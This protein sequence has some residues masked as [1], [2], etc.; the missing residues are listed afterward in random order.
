MA[1]S[2]KPSNGTHVRD[3]RRF[4][5]SSSSV[6]S[7]P[8]NRMPTTLHWDPGSTFTPERRL[9]MMGPGAT[10]EIV[11]E[12]VMGT[13]HE[14]FA[15]RYPHLRALF[16][17][18]TTRNGDRPYLVHGDRTITFAE[19]RRL[20]AATA[21]AL[22][23]EHDIGRGDRVAIA[24][25][26]RYEF[27]I[28]AWAV[29]V[30]G[31]V[32]VGLNGWWTGP[33]LEYG[34]GLTHPKL[35]IG[36]EERLARLTGL[37]PGL[38]RRGLE[39]ATVIW[40]EGDPPLPEVTIDEDD[41]FVILFTSGTTGRPKGAVLT[42]RNNIHWTQSIAL[43]SAAL[44]A[45]ATETCEIAALPLFHISGLNCQAISSVATGTKLVYMPPPGRWSPESQ[46]ALSEQHGVTTWRLVPTQAWRL[47]EHP[48]VDQY[49]V[50]SLRSIVGGGSLWS[51]NLL[52]R[53]AEKWPHARSGLV[54]GLGMTETNGTGATA[55]MPGLLDIPGNVGGPPPT[56]LIRVCQPSS[57]VQVEDDLVGEVQI[58][59]A[60]VF[61]GYYG[62]PAATE[63]ALGGD[64][65]YHTG[66]FGRI[67]QGLLFLEGRRSDLILRGGEN[68]YPAE[69]EDRLHEHP[70]I[71]D[72][73]VVGVPDR[74]LGEQVKAVVVRR[75]GS[76]LDADEVRT[77]AATALAPFKVPTLIEF[78]DS[79][80]RNVT[81]KVMKH[82]LDSPDPV[83]F[84]D[85]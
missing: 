1:A 23:R 51:P 5:P 7:H 79:L 8:R 78:R 12:V 21:A 33:E 49:D 28:L 20:V 27:V 48:H 50:A 16:E 2:T 68:I 71:T 81:G 59:S 84:A 36:D 30:L 57:D 58:R 67:A 65:W 13:R 9:S 80:P 18:G 6:R 31:G 42:H 73:V 17:D 72:V 44:G 85:A 26:N 11:E 45:P 34:I 4:Q 3:T 22:Q 38:P 25:A 43:R 46:L 62:D 41:P 52:E 69:I 60:S 15:R 83:P 29:I 39:E 61:L 35:L 77:W 70:A 75:P 66:D 24:S 47:L 82:L 37:V 40:F 55:V 56:A 54:V 64:R 19:A 32:V 14:V 53:L 10:F 63:A 74:V 76:A